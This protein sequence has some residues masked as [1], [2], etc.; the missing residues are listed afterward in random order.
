MKLFA[1]PVNLDTALFLCSMQGSLVFC[2]Q[3]SPVFS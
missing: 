1:R 2:L 3:F